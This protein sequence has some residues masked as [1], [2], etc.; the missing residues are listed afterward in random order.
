MWVPAFQLV[1]PYLALLS[2][3]NSRQD[4]RPDSY[5]FESDGK[6]ARCGNY[7]KVGK[8][9][10]ALYF[11]PCQYLLLTIY[12]EEKTGNESDRRF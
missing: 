2:S 7:G 1:Y 10:E 6:I 5:Q 4:P 8:G 11:S 9:K 3:T 12:S